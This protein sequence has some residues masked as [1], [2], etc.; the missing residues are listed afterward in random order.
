MRRMED[1]E[2]ESVSGDSIENAERKYVSGTFTS[3]CHSE[4]GLQS[5]IRLEKSRIY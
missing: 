2:E 3:R 4:M 1:R 5:N